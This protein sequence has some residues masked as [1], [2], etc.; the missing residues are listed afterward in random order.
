MKRKSILLLAIIMGLTIFICVIARDGQTTMHVVN[1]AQNAAAAGKTVDKASVNRYDNFKGFI[2]TLP[3]QDFEHIGD[4][5]EWV[6][7]NM[8]CQ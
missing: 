8:W 5:L 7:K 2:A 1:H 4:G 6:E 3:D